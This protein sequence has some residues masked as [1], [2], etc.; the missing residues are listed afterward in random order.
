MAECKI[1]IGVTLKIDDAYVKSNVGFSETYEQDP[2]GTNAKETNEIL[3]SRCNEALL[4][5]IVKQLKALRK[6]DFI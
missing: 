4:D 1:E 6:K 3:I 5:N 2:T